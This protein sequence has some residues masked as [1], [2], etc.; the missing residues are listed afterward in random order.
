MESNQAGRRIFWVVYCLE[1]EYAFNCSHASVCLIH[2]YRISIRLM[3]PLQLIADGDI[4]CPLPTLSNS[5]LEGFD[6]LRCW[7]QYSRTLS[8]AYDSLFSISATLNSDE[9]YFSNIDR[10]QRDLQSWK[11]SIPESLRPG[12]SLQQ[13]RSRYLHMQE[14]AFRVSFAYYNLQICISRLALHICPDQ[15]SLRRSESKMCLLAAARSIIESTPYIA[16]DPITPVW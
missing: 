13:H 4:S 10:I 3:C 2:C 14:L 15:R 5:A 9:E 6:W 1:K 11:D 16:I 7:A 8:R 12:S